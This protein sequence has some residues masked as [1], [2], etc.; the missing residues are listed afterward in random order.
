MSH[1]DKAIEKGEIIFEWKALRPNNTVW[2]AEVHLMKFEIDKKNYLQFTVSDIT[3]KRRQREE[4]INER[5]LLRTLIDNVPDAIYVRDRQ[6]KFVIANQELAKRLNLSS[7]DEVIG[8]KDSDFFDHDQAEAFGKMDQKVFEGKSIINYEQETIYPNGEKRTILVNKVPFYDESGQVKYLI[9]CNRDITERIRSQKIIKDRENY[10]SAI[11]ENVPFL[12]WLKDVNGRFLAVNTQFAL[13]C[14]KNS[15][16]EVIGKTDLDIWPR[17]LAEKYMADDR[18]VIN[19][20]GKKSVEEEINDK[21]VIKWFHT[22]K[23]VIRNS[24]GVVVGTTGIAQD[25]TERKQ[26]QIALQESEAKY[27][28]LFNDAPVLITISDLLTKKF[29]D[30]N[31]EALRI[32]GFSRDEMIGYTASE[33]GWLDEAQRNKVMQKLGSGGKIRDEEMIFTGKNGKQIIGFVNI[34]IIK[35][36]GRDCILT[37]LLDITERKKTEAELEK[38]KNHLQELVNERTKEIEAINIELKK[39]IEL[40]EK[41]EKDL[42]LA[43]Q[44]EKELNILKSRFISTASHE[45]RTPMTSM[46][47]SA[48]LIK[49]YLNRWPEEKIKTH[50][51]RI[52]GSISSLTELID[53]VILINRAESKKL[54]F[55]PVNTNL[56]NECKKI[57]NDL[58]AYLTD[59]HN[60]IYQFKCNKKCYVIDPKQF[61]IIVGNLLSNAIKYS[62]KGGDILLKVEESQNNLKITVQDHGIGIP[63]QDIS[64]LYEPFHRAKN[65]EDIKGSGLGLSIVKN[66]VALCSGNISVESKLGEGTTFIV[67]IPFA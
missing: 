39:E 28:K 9:G 45:F 8:K 11:L 60:F 30:V 50:L 36:S 65:V 53:D 59:K 35:V 63:E 33:I 10:L 62:T 61:E 54:E 38:H 5:N 43:L 2:D 17:Y 55:E 26:A 12:L 44:K 49:K 15:P 51:D 42:A 7:P 27:Q 6:N 14:G 13:S 46:L 3:E 66:S 32:S 37:T 57:I 16:E 18:E 58:D 34:E 4:L 22:Y 47:M 67:T 29:I 40:K 25:I 48:D 20:G 23:T 31:K 64:R 52:I 1:I 56:D 19:S 24:E 21:N 41:A